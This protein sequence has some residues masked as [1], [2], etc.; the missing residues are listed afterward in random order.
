M[1]VI[2]LIKIQI[3]YACKWFHL[4]FSEKKCYPEKQFAQTEKFGSGE[5]STRRDGGPQR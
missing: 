2:L 5:V 4:H 3:W 1:Q